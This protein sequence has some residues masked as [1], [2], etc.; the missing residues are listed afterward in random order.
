[1]AITP[2]KP[3]REDVTSVAKVRVWLK[4]TISAGGDTLTVAGIKEVWSVDVVNRPA[5]TFTYTTTG[6]SNSAV[7]LTV[8]VTASCT[9]G[10]TPLVVYGR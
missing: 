1:M 9:G 6:A 5:T 3:D 2:S 4:P 8:T 7:V 10:V